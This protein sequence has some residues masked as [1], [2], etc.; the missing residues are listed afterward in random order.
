MHHYQFHIGDY[1]K[2][3]TH[4]TPIEH[5][6]YRSLIDWYYLDEQP[7]PKITH[8]VLR[9]LS[10][11]LDSEKLLQNVLQDFFFE[12]ENG[13]KHKRIDQDIAAYHAVCEVNKENGKRGGRP[14]KT[15]SVFFANRNESETKANETLTIN[16]KPLTNNHKP[17]NTHDVISFTEVNNMCRSSH[18]V[19]TDEKTPKKTP[20]KATAL[21]ENW[22]L[23]K[24]WGDW[25]LEEFPSLN[26]EEVRLMASMFKDHWLANATKANSK[27]ADWFATWRNWVRRS[28]PNKANV[29]KNG[30]TY[31]ESVINTANQIFGRKKHGARHETIDITPQHTAGGN[32]EDFPADGIGIR[33]ESS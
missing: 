4:L 12:C 32:T 30:M 16:H 6:I 26:A 33:E 29:P 25:A 9:R 8:S 3:T 20:K 15:H 7:I 27:K 11:G 19:S 24:T 13:W 1:R 14:K 31:H 5:Y 18:S 2:D 21:P 17:L 22:V 28:D 10:L 23:P